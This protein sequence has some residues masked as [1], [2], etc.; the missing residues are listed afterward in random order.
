MAI[1]DVNAQSNRNHAVPQNIM[2]VEFKII[3]DLSMRQFSYILIFGLMGYMNSQL[4]VG[5]FKWPLTIFFSL[6]GIALAF[7][8]VQDR[9]LDVWL[10]NF[11]KSVYK[12]TQMVWKKSVVLPTAFLYDNINVLKQELIT[13]APTSSRRKLEEYLDYSKKTLPSDPL[14]I[15]EA[16]YIK[17]VRDSFRGVRV[18]PVEVEV[19]PVE[20]RPTPVSEIIPP[21]AV[22]SVAPTP[23]EAPVA[24]V[25]PIKVEEKK[26][27]EVL[28]VPTIK[29]EEPVPVIKPI[30][31]RA[32][33]VPKISV[34]AISTPVI[35]VAEEITYAPI[36]PDRHSGRRFTSFLPSKGE[37]VLPIRGERVLMT[38]D[39]SEIEEDLASKT[40]KLQQLLSQIRQS[41]IKPTKRPE[42]VKTSLPQELPVKEQPLPTISEKPEVQITFPSTA[43]KRDETPTITITP[44]KEE[45][46]ILRRSDRSITQ[47]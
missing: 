6:L 27:E 25:K 47:M 46:P 45:L 24:E 36:T 33:V 1:Q 16:E 20:V 39:Q 13:L 19:K 29:V 42:A 5:L 41:N 21:K 7:V 3:G 23:K 40:E 8:P 22:I 35:P 11:I 30:E 26:V 14:D 37:L 9:G 31:T 43:T 15:P 4:M 12:P 38:S 18:E 28:P 32:P 10:V 2:D 44:V 34:E 17:K